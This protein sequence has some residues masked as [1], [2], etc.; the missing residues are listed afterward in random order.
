MENPIKIHDLGDPPLF[1]ET[2]MS[3]P[4]VAILLVILV[5]RVAVK[6]GRYHERLLRL[7]LATARGGGGIVLVTW[8]RDA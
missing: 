8:H 6:Y 2:P 4:S 5:T 3:E 7:L 1:V